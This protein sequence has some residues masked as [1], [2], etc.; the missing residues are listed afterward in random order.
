MVNFAWA[1]WYRNCTIYTFL[2]W[3]TVHPTLSF[4]D[5]FTIQQVF[6]CWIWPWIDLEV[7]WGH[8]RARD[9]GF[10]KLEA[11]LWQLNDTKACLEITLWRCFDNLAG[12]EWT[13]RLSSGPRLTSRRSYGRSFVPGSLAIWPNSFLYNPFPNRALS[14]FK[15]YKIKPNYDQT[16]VLTG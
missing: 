2:K 14:F 1:S 9:L 8:L 4:F 6:N 10:P 13:R 15:K 11:N 16:I 5:I 12:P 3:V 7:I